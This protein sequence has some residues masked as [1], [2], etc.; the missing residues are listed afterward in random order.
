MRNSAA[1]VSAYAQAMTGDVKEL[2]MRALA[3]AGMG[4]LRNGRSKEAME[5]YKR[6]MVVAP[7]GSL[8]SFE[9]KCGYAVRALP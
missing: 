7:E 9:A 5:Q 6:L 1:R 8:K 4:N 2:Y 3:V